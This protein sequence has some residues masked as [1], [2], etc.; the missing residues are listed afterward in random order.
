METARVQDWKCDD[1]TTQRVISSAV[2]IFDE[3]RKT[4]TDLLP[5]HSFYLSEIATREPGALLDGM[6]GVYIDSFVLGAD[7][8]RHLVYHA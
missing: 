5:V 4:R 2:A 7:H 3:D 6:V 8:T 1:I